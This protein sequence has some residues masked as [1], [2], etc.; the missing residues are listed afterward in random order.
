MAGILPAS[1]L[2]TGMPLAWS[3]FCSELDEGWVSVYPRPV[4]LSG[5]LS[6]FVSHALG[7][8]GSKLLARDLPRGTVRSGGMKAP[9]PFF[10]SMLSEAVECRRV[11]AK[12]ALS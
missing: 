8:S 12:D 9:P 1:I 11:V 7:A 5:E 6:D 2:A 10:A 4:R 3:M